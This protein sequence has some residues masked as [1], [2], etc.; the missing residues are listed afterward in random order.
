MSAR[1]EEGLETIEAL[2]DPSEPLT[3]IFPKAIDLP[4]QL[5]Q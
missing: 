5:V 4:T 3:E 1:V 2:M